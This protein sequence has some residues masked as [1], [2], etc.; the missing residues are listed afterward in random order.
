MICVWWLND[1]TN[2]QILLLKW[3]LVLNI[4]QDKTEKQFKTFLKI[5][6]SYSFGSDYQNCADVDDMSKEELA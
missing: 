3:E 4:W 2:F 6:R 1:L 5:S